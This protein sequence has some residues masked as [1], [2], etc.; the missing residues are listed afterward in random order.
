L[1]DVDFSARFEAIRAHVEGSAQP[2]GVMLAGVDP[3]A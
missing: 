1:T 2:E 3:V